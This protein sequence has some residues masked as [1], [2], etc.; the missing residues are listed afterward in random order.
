MR[1]L[2]LRLKNLNSLVGEWH[3]DFTHPEYEGNRIF[4]II[5]PTGAGKSTLLD[6]ICLAL[7]G[8]TPRIAKISKDSNELMAR[9]TGECLAEVTFET[10]HGK[11][12]CCWSQ[13]RSR[14]K[15]GENLQAPRREVV[16]ALTNAVLESQ[17]NK[18]NDL[19]EEL[20]GMDFQRFTRSMMLAQGGFDAFLK[21]SPSERAP[22]LEQITGTEIYSEISK[23]TFERNK[24]EGQKLRNIQ[25]EYAAISI[26][27]E[28][29]EAL[30]RQELEA[31]QAEVH[32]R[33]AQFK[34]LS[35]KKAWRQDMDQ[36]ALELQRNEKAFQ[37]YL[38]EEL[39][40]LG[41]MHKLESGLK[42]LNFAADFAHLRHLG[43]A[44]SA[45]LAKLVKAGQ[46]KAVLEKAA[47]AAH[48]KLEISQKSCEAALE[49]YKSGAELIKAV[50]ALEI[51]LT[52]YTEEQQ[53][54]S[55]QIANPR[56]ATP[57]SNQP[58]T[59]TKLL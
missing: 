9:H 10:A 14:N 11:Y 3:I 26:F 39:A 34:L 35:S 43:S 7:Y 52:R 56:K 58:G 16:D 28:E 27:S 40:A 23:K 42:A 6:A 53:K 24:L 38:E 19:V 31:K 18:A 41:D 17:L 49:A 30:F 4:A 29:E 57:Q 36:V 5:G 45:D 33:Q 2:H 37:H 54:N 55:A 25:A 1:I 21:A 44:Q 46:D 20:T 32:M 12:R 47:G 22:I 59:D 51:E 50:R 15:P 48:V 13:H 8:R